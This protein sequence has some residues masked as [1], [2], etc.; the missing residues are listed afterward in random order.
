MLKQIA[1]IVAGGFL[2]I[3]LEIMLD[4][5]GLVNTIVYGAVNAS[6]LVAAVIAFAVTGAGVAMKK[7]SIAFLGAGMVA[8]SVPQIAGKALAPRGVP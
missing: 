2:D 3:V 5:A 1:L 6:D 4:K 7:E 8:V